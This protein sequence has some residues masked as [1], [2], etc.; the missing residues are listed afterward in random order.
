MQNFFFC[1]LEMLMKAEDVVIS[2]IEKTSIPPPPRKKWKEKILTLQLTKNH[3]LLYQ[4]S[5]LHTIIKSM[6]I[7]GC[8][9]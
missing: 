7:Y 4:M 6:L 5:K 2:L 1:L 3:V 9:R 8:C